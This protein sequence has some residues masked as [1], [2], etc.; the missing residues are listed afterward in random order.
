[1]SEDLYKED[2]KDLNVVDEHASELTITG[3]SGP[4]ESTKRVYAK[5][6]VFLT[7]AFNEVKLPL[8]QFLALWTVLSV[9]FCIAG[10]YNVNA[11]GYALLLGS[12]FSICGTTLILFSGFMS[13]DYHRHVCAALMLHEVPM[14]LTHCTELSIYILHCHLRFALCPYACH[15]RLSGLYFLFL[16][17]Y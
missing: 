11:L 14:F 6:E 4:S 8:L 16:E 10:H 12:M 1:M 3:R 17:I 15:R 2:P 9:I 13:R 5:K 7:V